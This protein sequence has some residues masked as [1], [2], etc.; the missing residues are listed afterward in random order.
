MILKILLIRDFSEKSF[1]P[2]SRKDAK[3]QLIY[4]KIFAPW[5]LSGKFYNLIFQS[6]FSFQIFKSSNY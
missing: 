2:Q 3:K 4:F 1:S 6:K 5:R